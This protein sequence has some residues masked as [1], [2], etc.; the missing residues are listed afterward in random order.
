MT[1]NTSSD[2]KYKEKSV[3]QSLY[4]DDKLSSVEIAKKYDVDPATIRYWMDKYGIERRSYTRAR[5]LVGLTE[6]PS[7]TT[8][9]N[10]YS[11]WQ[12]QYKKNNHQVLEHRLLAV[13]KYGFDAV[14]GM[15]VHHKNCCKWDNRF[16]NIELLSPSEHQYK[17][18]DN[19]SKGGSVEL[20]TE[21]ELITELVSWFK[22]YG[23]VPTAEDFR[24]ETSTPAP[25]TYLN[26]F[27]SWSKAKK[28]AKE[29]IEQ[30]VIK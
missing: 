21:E 11:A 6:L 26:R 13:A 3:L 12:T 18:P 15:Q 16:E 2:A 8:T 22:R 28:K 20:Y 14:K 5:E 30:T 17:H 29:A 19:R 24:K 4:H 1:K 9:S 7:Y 27:G 25:K 23:E 10:G